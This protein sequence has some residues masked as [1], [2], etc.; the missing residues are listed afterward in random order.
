MCPTHLIYL[1]CP[2]GTIFCSYFC[3]HNVGNICGPFLN[4]K[5]PTKSQQNWQGYTLQPVSPEW[6]CLSGFSAAW[7]SGFFHNPVLKS[8]KAIIRF[9]QVLVQLLQNRVLTLDPAQWCQTHVVLDLKWSKLATGGCKSLE[10]KGNQT[11]LTKLQFLNG[12]A[13]F[14]S[15]QKTHWGGKKG[16]NGLSQLKCSQSCSITAIY[17]QV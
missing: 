6:A 3:F 1:L 2:A 15:T 14:W 8:I 12:L 10:V 17:R 4:H 11:K 16:A 7:S 13:M 5:T 9:Q